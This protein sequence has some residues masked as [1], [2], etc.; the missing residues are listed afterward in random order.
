MRVMFGS[1]VAIVALVAA[2]PVRAQTYDP[3]YP[4]C[5][6]V[7]GIEGGYISCGYTSMA[8]CQLSASGRAAQCIVNPY[9]AGAPAR[10]RTTR[11]PY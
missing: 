10:G 11:R 3:S 8:Q 4:V 2:A 7:Y 9:F 6:Q 1:I 5:L